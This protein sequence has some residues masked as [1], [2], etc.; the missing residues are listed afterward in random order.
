MVF[1]VLKMIISRH[2]SISTFAWGGAVSEQMGKLVNQLVTPQAKRVGYVGKGNVEIEDILG[3]RILQTRQG[4]HPARIFS[5]LIVGGSSPPHW[6][7][8]RR[9]V[10]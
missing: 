8:R 3:M 7:R 1:V 4:L 10:Y 2:L 5:I 6:V 9:G